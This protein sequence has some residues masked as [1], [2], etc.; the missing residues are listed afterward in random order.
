MAFIKLFK[1]KGAVMRV[2]DWIVFRCVVGRR[3]TTGRSKIRYFDVERER[4]HVNFNGF[5]C[6]NRCNH[7]NPNFYPHFTNYPCQGFIVNNGEITKVNG[8]DAHTLRKHGL[9]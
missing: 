5:K 7:T 1:T 6:N 4:V 2:G 9:L 3:L 8:V